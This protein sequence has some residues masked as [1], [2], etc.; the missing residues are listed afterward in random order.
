MI[1]IHGK[2]YIEVKDRVK[3]FREEKQDWSIITSV[4]HIGQ[5]NSIIIKAS[6]IDEKGTQRATGLAHEFQ[7]DKSSMVNMTSWVENC[8][9]SAIGRALACLGYGIDEAY[10]SANEV[11]TAQRKEQEIKIKLHS[12]PWASAIVPIGKNKGKALGE[13][14]DKSIAWYI[15]NFKANEQY[16]DSIAFRKALDEAKA[17]ET[18]NAEVEPIDEV[19]EQTANEP[20]D[21][22][23]DEEVPF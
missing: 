19:A 22:D 6:I 15:E 9:T 13:L 11:K 12:Q 14:N 18:K 20:S 21:P 23:L 3:A 10:A 16:E 1:Q 2:N 8:E 17:C 4:E 7:A 5:N